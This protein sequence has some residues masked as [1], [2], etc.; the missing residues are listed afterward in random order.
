MNNFLVS[1]KA[2]KKGMEKIN[3]QIVESQN[4]VFNLEDFNR[5]KNI[6]KEKNGGATIVILSFSKFNC[7]EEKNETKI[8]FKK[9]DK[10][11]DLLRQ[12][13]GTI[14]SIG[15]G[16]INSEYQVTVYFEDSRDTGWYMKDGRISNNH[17]SRILYFE[18]E[19]S[20]LNL[21]KLCAEG[22]E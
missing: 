15:C 19:V 12:E 5:A 21:K 13:F 4:E 2:L 18:N 16:A 11:F 9:G 20:K 10:V 22:C 14:D 8:I 7:T 3:S 6:I 17:S 1:Y